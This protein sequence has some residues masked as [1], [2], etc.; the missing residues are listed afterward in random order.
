[1][2][3]GDLDVVF[4]TFMLIFFNL[5]YFGL[6]YY[7]LKR[8]VNEHK[9]FTHAKFMI[10]EDDMN[11]YIQN[12]LNLHF[13]WSDLRKFERI[14]FGRGGFQ[15]KFVPSSAVEAIQFRLYL[16]IWNIKKHEKIVKKLKQLASQKKIAFSEEKRS[17][18]RSRRKKRRVEED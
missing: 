9:P 2:F 3:F 7:P 5:L 4:V 15:L 13:S 14:R 10:S 11:I 6:L 16:L 18:R 17:Y 1:M 12:H 8:K